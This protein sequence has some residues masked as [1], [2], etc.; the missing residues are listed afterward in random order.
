[1]LNFNSERKDTGKIKVG[2][3]KRKKSSWTETDHQREH[4]TRQEIEEKRI[5]RWQMLKMLQSASLGG[6]H[7]CGSV[8]SRQGLKSQTRECLLSVPGL[9]LAGRR[10]P[11][12]CWMMSSVWPLLS[13]ILNSNRTAGPRKPYGT[14]NLAFWSLSRFPI[15]E[16]V[17]DWLSWIVEGAPAGLLREGLDSGDWCRAWASDSQAVG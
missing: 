3:E 14:L 16:D 9:S 5:L 13:N 6:N 15:D 10:V 1:M 17:G 4:R 2:C 7:Y 8:W 12:F 11:P